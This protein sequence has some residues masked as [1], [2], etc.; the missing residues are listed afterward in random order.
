MRILVYGAG[1]LG[2]LY[3]AR[4]HQAGQDVTLLAR[5]QRLTD[6]R[7]HGIVLADPVSGARRVTPVRV[8]EA[9]APDDAYDLVLVV[10]RKNQVGA[11]L[12]ILAANRATPNVLF[13]V[14]NAAGPDAYTAALGR[15]RVLLGF[16]GAGGRREGEVV[17]ARLTQSGLQVTTLGE[18]D[19]Q[20]TPRLSRIAA[21]FTAAGL[22]VAL[23]PHMDAWLKTHAAAVVPIANAV[24]AAG[25][26]LGR[27]ARTPD[28]L[29]LMV[30]A[31]KEGL[32]ALR[33]LGIPPT[34]L[35]LR[36]LVGWL[37]E[38]IQVPVLG[39]IYQTEGA[40][41]VIEHHANAARDEMDTLTAEVRDLIT[42]AGTPSPAFDRLAA[43]L[44]PTVPPLPEGSAE[45]GLDRRGVWIALGIGLLAL[46]LVWRGLVGI[47]RKSRG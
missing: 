31:M 19:G 30:R 15:D 6:L 46:S 16:A 36:I 34:P 9:L 45:I 5:G 8:V 17:Y 23:S 28:A 42:L 14:N 47:Y 20:L 4:L 35:K 26:D 21:A 11:V 25:G 29:I 37:P 24:Y 27:V 13:L 7:E 12:P 3:A 2:S 32:A 22:P 39:R 18:L 1:V 40:R 43:Y 10:M 41:L 38:A 33:A 44:D